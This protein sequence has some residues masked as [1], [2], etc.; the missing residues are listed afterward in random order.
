MI[1]L[2]LNKNNKEKKYAVL[3]L[4]LVRPV[5]YQWFPPLGVHKFP[6]HIGYDTGIAYIGM[7][8]REIY[9]VS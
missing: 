6:W 7:V 1:S 3:Y 5:R 2:E 9:Q 4:P 8:R